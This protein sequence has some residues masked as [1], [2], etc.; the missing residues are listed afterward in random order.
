MGSNPKFIHLNFHNVMAG[1]HQLSHD[2]VVEEVDV[3]TLNHPYVS[4]GSA[5]GKFR[6]IFEKELSR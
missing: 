3:V 4:E 2:T 5:F 1:A 6:W